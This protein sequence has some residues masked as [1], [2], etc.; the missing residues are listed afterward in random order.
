MTRLVAL[1][2]WWDEHPDWLADVVRSLVLADV[3]ALVAVDGSY[4][5]MPGATASSPHG[6]AAAIARTATEVGIVSE[7]VVP[8]DLWTSECVKRTAMFGYAEAH[9]PD[10]LL[11][12]DA[13]EV[14][15]QAPPD[16]KAHLAA[17]DRD[18]AEVASLEHAAPVLAAEMDEEMPQVM[19][20]RWVKPR[21]CLFRAIPGLRVGDA[22]YDYLT[23][24]GRNLWG[25]GDEP[26]LQVRDMVIDHRSGR[27]DP[28]RRAAKDAY[29]EARDTLGVERHRVTSWDTASPEKVAETEALLARALERAR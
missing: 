14:I 1:L 18:C 4:P 27:R 26:A 29:R 17:T 23:P 5:H 9:R 13:D 11:V 28:V 12:I 25:D 21:R 2:S 7:V 24:D 8:G 15:L 22:H 3:D 16:L 19:A 10:W 6:Q 20:S